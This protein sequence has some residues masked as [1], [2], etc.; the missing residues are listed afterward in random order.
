VSALFAEAFVP[1]VSTVDLSVAGRYEEYSDF[2]DTFNP[3]VGLRW[4]AT[5]DMSLR[6][7]F[8][9]SFRAASL[10][11][12]DPESSGY[13]LYADTLPNADGATTYGI[14]VA[15][16]N[17][18][19]KP[20]RAKTWSLGAVATPSFLSGL[21]V[22][23]SYFS[24]DYE[25][26]ILALR[27]TP[28]LLTSPFYT[29]FVTF[30]PTSEQVDA[31]LNSGL[32]LNAQINPSEV[33]FIADERRQ[34]LGSTLVRGV[35]FNVSY[36]RSSAWG[37]LQAGVAGEY[38]TEYETAPAPGAPA[39]NVLGRINYPQRYRA[40]A[41]LGWRRGPFDIVTYIN[42]NDS[43]VQNTTS[44]HRK[45]GDHTTVDL[46][47]GIELDQAFRPAVLEG[48]MLALDVRNLF[49][50]EPPFVDLPGGYDPQ[51]AN[52]IG[53]LIGLTLRKAW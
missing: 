23:A 15:G 5:D 34:N 21:S 33:T 11:E 3:K 50:N 24:I 14:G 4:Q 17:P 9:R 10:S 29:G 18:D 12:V 1:L 16:G 27:G 48:T 49:D 19:L 51:V 28:G 22:E 35:D 26:Q 52:P 31:L 38:F 47:F 13:G 30:D 44:P 41:T 40:Q 37:E 7:S 53:R 32:P 6:A 39:V 42:H 25:N 20:E 2:G 45:V 46:H 43:Y 8:G 36:R